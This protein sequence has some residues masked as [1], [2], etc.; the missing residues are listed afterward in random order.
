MWAHVKLR[1]AAVVQRISVP[2]QG[3]G[4]LYQEW[5]HEHDWDWMGEWS[6][7]MQGFC[8]PSEVFYFPRKNIYLWY[9]CIT[10]F[11]RGDLILI[12]VFSSNI[13]TSWRQGGGPVNFVLIALNTVAW[14]RGTQWTFAQPLFRLWLWAGVLNSL[15]LH[16]GSAM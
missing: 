14:P 4:Y 9:S 5:Y 15:G 12:S 6:G 8:E 11:P 16:P 1:R 10:T 13:G 3:W 7:E 2:V